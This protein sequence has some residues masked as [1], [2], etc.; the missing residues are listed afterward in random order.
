MDFVG[1]KIYKCGDSLSKIYKCGEVVWEKS[2]RDYSKEY[3][4]I[5]A[6]EDGDFPIKENRN[7]LYYRLN[8]GSWTM[9][10]ADPTT[11]HLQSGDT[12]EF[13][14]NKNG[15][16][17]AFFQNTLHYNVY[18]NIESILNGDDFVGKTDPV[19]ISTSFAS[20]NVVEAGNLILP[21]TSLWIITPQ[22][23]GYV[24]YNAAFNN[25][26]KL[27]SAPDLPADNLPR[28][29]YGD[30][31]SLCRKLTKAP[32]LPATILGADCY[33]DMFKG[34]FRLIEAPEL[35]AAALVSWCYAGMFDGCTRLN[36]IKCLATDLTAE[37]ALTD[38]LN[39]VFPIGTFVKKSGVEWPSGPSGIP[40][41]WT[42][43][44]VE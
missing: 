2:G 38:W 17:M 13:K 28:G 36:Y 29:A 30:M 3:F 25:C 10:E 4:T 24:S 21:A 5:E 18:G 39:G 12:V 23:T 40:E 6:L 42:I 15:L 11:L 34:C 7:S 37:N 32:K 26:Q 22:S 16:G 33:L 27:I 41:G 35:P 31:F 14:G 1:D 19:G 44:D 8:G 20:S 43:I 9:I